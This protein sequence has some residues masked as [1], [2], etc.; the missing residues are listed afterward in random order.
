VLCGLAYG[1]IAAALGYGAQYA[2]ILGGTLALSSTAVVVQTLTERGQQ[3]CPVGL[4]GTAILIFQDIC[5]IFI[6]ILATSIAD[7]GSS[8]SEGALAAAI[9]SAALKAAIAFLA[10]VLIGR[11]AMG[12]GAGEVASAGEDALKVERARA[13]KG[14][15]EVMVEVD[16]EGEGAGASASEEAVEVEGAGAGARKEAVEVEL[17][18]EDAGG[19]E[20]ALENAVEIAVA[21][22][23]GGSG[24]IAGEGG[25]E[26]QTT[27]AGKVTARGRTAVHSNRY[28]PSLEGLRPRCWS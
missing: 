13:V 22:E 10:A 19:V 11:Y 5:A 4:T 17:E 7:A 18:V 24:E 25:L 8:S 2:I 28:L 12:E 14:A 1:A 20:H 23:V 9:S 26:R 27:G 3:N 15:V 21:R 6:L 16:G